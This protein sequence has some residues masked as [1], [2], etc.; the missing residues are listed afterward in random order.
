MIIKPRVPRFNIRSNPTSEP[1]NWRVGKEGKG[2]EDGTD[3]ME[4]EGTRGKR[5]NYLFK[6]TASLTRLATSCTRIILAS[7][8]SRITTE[9]KAPELGPT[10]PHSLTQ[11]FSVL[12][13]QFEFGARSGIYDCTFR[14]KTV[15]SVILGDELIQCLGLGLSAEL[16]RP[17]TKDPRGSR[18]DYRLQ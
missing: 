1:N 8:H 12:T 16:T 15:P 9:T 7:L 17:I 5:G 6:G 3:I 18:K 14:L 4:R 11:D 10:C 13:P 2:V